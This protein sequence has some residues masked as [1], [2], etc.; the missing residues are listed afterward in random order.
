MAETFESK[1]MNG[2]QKP[3][4]KKSIQ[5]FAMEWIT[6]EGSV[7]FST[8]SSL[9]G[10]FRVGMSQGSVSKNWATIAGLCCGSLLVKQMDSYSTVANAIYV[11]QACIYKSV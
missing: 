9:D 5:F 10:S 3:S 2:E 6:K 1:T 7:T 11:L 4:C 8:L